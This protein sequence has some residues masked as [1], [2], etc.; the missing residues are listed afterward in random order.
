LSAVIILGHISL[1]VFD[2]IVA[3]SGKDIR[4]DVPAIYMWTTTFDAN[5]FARGA[6]IGILMLMTVALL[7]IPYLSYSIRGEADV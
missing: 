1:K 5:N 4:L 7:V 6:A 2:L 3:I